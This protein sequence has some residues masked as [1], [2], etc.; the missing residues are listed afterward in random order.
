MNEKWFSLSVAECE[1][2][3]KTNAASGLSR[4]AARSAWYK[5]ER[6]NSA[7]HILFV[8]KK[9][10]VGKM[11]G[12]IFADFSLVMLLGLALLS[13]LFEE[14]TVGYTVL[15]ICIVNL[16][17][18]FAYYYCSQ[19]SME[20]MN[21]YFLPTA[22]VIRGGR[23]YR[24]RFENIVRGDVIIFEK[25]DIVPADARLITSDCLTV[26]M[27]ADK[28]RYITL[29]KQAEGVVMADEKNPAKHINILHAGSVITEGSARAIVYAT[30]TYTYLGAMCGEIPEFYSDNI[31][32]ELKKMKR[33]CSKISLVSMLCILPFC[34]L[35]LLLSHI[36]GGTSTL[37]LT[38]LTALSISA[39][40]MTQLT[41]T[42]CKVFFIK[43][44]KDL[45]NCKSPCAIRT[46]D[47]FDK[48]SGIRTVF[49]LDGSALTDGVLHFD[50]IF[51]AE[52]ESNTFKATTPTTQMLFDMVSLYNSAE[53][54][55]LTVGL[56]LPDR[57]KAGL[58]EFAALGHSDIGALKIR[59]PIHSYM[60]GSDSNPIDRV[61]YSDR[62]VKTVLDVARTPEI[63][64]QCS[65][66]V[67]S[68]QIQPLTSVGRDKLKH[69][70]FRHINDGKT[71]LVFTASKM[72]NSGKNIDKIFIGAV[73]LKEGVDKNAAATIAA[74]E[75]RGIKAIGFVR[76]NTPV[77]IPQIPQE[78]RRGF[79]ASKNDFARKQVPITYKFG[80]INTYIDFEENDI[81]SLLRL[82]RSEGGRVAVIGF[83][84][85]APSVIE[86]ADVFI[87]CAPIV[88]VLAAKNE[89]E[90]YKTELVG[91]VN[92]VS[93]TQ[94]V[95][96]ESDILLERPNGSIGG[97][98][99]LYNALS[100][101]SAAYRNLLSFFKYTL[102]AQLLRAILVGLPMLVGKPI[103]DARHI[104]LCSFIIDVFVLLMLADDRSSAPRGDMDRYRLKTLSEHIA[105]NKVLFLN[106]IFTSLFAVFLPM[107]MDFVNIFGSYLYRVEY[108]LCTLLMLQFLVI[109]YI[110]YSRIKKASLMLKN[111]IFLG[112]AMCAAL[113]TAC[114][115]IIPP[116]GRLFDVFYYPLPYLIAGFLP[117]ILFICIMELNP[118]I[119][120]KK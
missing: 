76:S 108:M 13:V 99:A 10:G 64:S 33:T 110:R 62:G 68:G 31:P 34:V 70:Y 42:L 69:T 51:T 15:G 119:T 78:L 87:S 100:A 81:L 9:K 32:E 116:L 63:F 20:H 73:V 25:G 23:L 85:F 8:R 24:V 17:I 72:E 74:L 59:C 89:E 38:F 11:I 90:L 55:M 37:S 49:M 83:S 2:K 47:A 117:P 107:L 82:A 86:A 14:K 30:G 93:A 29:K 4:K 35:S 96:S 113:F 50:K 98:S 48:L 102:A 103:L 120:K 111:K 16:G 60:T 58:G 56:S 95:K 26:A 1:Q 39:S 27:R 19:R 54:E 7:A 3:L 45:L 105:K 61:F 71:V 46:T 5:E 67:I 118:S 106:V 91:A 57:F 53:S 40:C 41:C 36:D 80:E 28:E 101:S 109:Y 6:M 66:S 52:G 92:S 115:F 114:M 88:D 44:I 94:T 22:K 43:K 84:D 18:S 104:L 21:L 65:Y 12:E 112:I 79:C 77:G 97:I 75:D